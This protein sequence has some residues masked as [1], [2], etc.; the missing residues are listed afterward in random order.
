LAIGSGG[1]FGKGFGLSTQKAFFLPEVDNDFVFAVIAEELGLIGAA[2]VLIAFLV[3]AWRGLRIANSAQDELG[4]LIAL[5]A[6][7]L[8]CCQAF[9]HM[10]VA[11]GILPTKGLTLPF[12]STGGW[13]LIVSCALAGL[14]MNVSLRRLPHGA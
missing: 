1:V 13:S 2:A 11:T 14:L 9:C 6:T 10:G 4:R 8:L 5:G 7:W 3:L 12:F